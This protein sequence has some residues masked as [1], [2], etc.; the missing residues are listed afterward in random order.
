MSALAHQDP[1]A[2]EQRVEDLNRQVKL[3][4]RTEKRLYATQREV[5]RQIRRIEALNQF[6]LVAP[7]S[8]D[9]AAI[10]GHALDMLAASLPVHGALAVVV[11][12]RGD[13]LPILRGAD[14]THHPVEVDAELASA[15]ERTPIPLDAEVIAGAS[16]IEASPLSRWL[17]ARVPGQRGPTL[18]RALVFFS[19]RTEATEVT[20]F[21]LARSETVS[22]HDKVAEEPDL[23]FLRLARQ[24]VQSALTIAR[25]TRMLERRV[26]LR[27]RELAQANT[28]LEERLAELHATQRRLVEVSR[29]AGMAEVATSVLH[30]VGNVLNSVNVSAEIVA[31]LARSSRAVGLQ[32]AM[33]LL[34]A[35][36]DPRAFLAQ[37]DRAATWIQYVAAGVDAL[38]EDRD[39]VLEELALLGKNIDHIKAIVSRQQSHAKSRGVVERFS[40]AALVEDALACGAC[41]ATRRLRVD[42]DIPTDCVVETDRHKLLEIVV[43]LVSNACQAVQACGGHGRIAIRARPCEHTVQIE[44]VDDGVGIAA[45]LLD[46]IFTHG[47]TTKP[48]GHGYGLHASA[49][50]AIELGGTLRAASEGPGRGATFT[51][52]VPRGRAEED[53]R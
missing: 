4:V 2:L 37:D 51:L 47:F 17:E 24:H 50:A 49:C 14:G 42:R 21:V 38:S 18:R 10:L 7:A 44:V 1:R 41:D 25:S 20:S 53:G 9:D 33:A 40:V 35:Q 29:K 45:E 31:G 48:H 34:R 32:R 15:I 28:E 39:R 36:P 23:A 22:F 13:L 8:T 12:E 46:R 6:A 5:G 19:L 52:A 26:H 3:L 43:N 30:N 11:D 27:T 16:E